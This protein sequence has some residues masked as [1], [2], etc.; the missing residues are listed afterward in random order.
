MYVIHKHLKSNQRVFK[1]SKG[2]P[3]IGF[4]LILNCHEDP[5]TRHCLLNGLDDIGW[6]LRYWSMMWGLTVWRLIHG[7]WMILSH[8][9]H[10]GA[11][12]KLDR[13]MDGLTDGPGQQGWFRDVCFSPEVLPYRRQITLTAL[14][15]TWPKFWIQTLW[16]GTINRSE[17]LALQARRSSTFPWLAC[18]STESMFFHAATEL[19]WPRTVQDTAE[20]KPKFVSVQR[21]P[22]SPALHRLCMACKGPLQGAERER[23]SERR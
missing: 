23:E 4:F 16:H 1:E 10:L 22:D 8:W 5:N 3:W 13:L 19:H 20:S 2:H 14:R 6:S 17:F 7:F 21:R 11:K 12:D 15:W 18:A 9:G